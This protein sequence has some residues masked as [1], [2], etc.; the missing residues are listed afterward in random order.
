M[1]VICYL[2]DDQAE[3]LE[4]DRLKASW[5]RDF[6]AIRF[7]WQFGFFHVF[8]HWQELIMKHSAFVGFPIDLRMEHR[9]VAELAELTISC[10]ARAKEWKDMERYGKH[11]VTFDP[12]ITPKNANRGVPHGT[13][14]KFSCSMV[15]LV[16]RK[17]LRSRR[18]PRHLR[19]GGKSA[20]ECVFLELMR[21]N[22]N[23]TNIIFKYV[24]HRP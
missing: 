3:F 6:V 8:P 23:I 9:Q 18:K 7:L 5:F 1:E 22:R 19:R 15:R 17:R 4:S 21:A 20:P 13:R 16:R 11:C 12:F 2:K 14:R 24:Q 10:D